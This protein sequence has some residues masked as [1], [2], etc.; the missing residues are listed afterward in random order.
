M[1]H[2]IVCF[3]PEL[4]IQLIPHLLKQ[5]GRRA[6]W[7]SPATFLASISAVILAMAKKNE[8]KRNK[9]KIYLRAALYIK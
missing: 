1:F 7:C 4:E 8:K 6:H 9:M 2:G 5:S 3:H